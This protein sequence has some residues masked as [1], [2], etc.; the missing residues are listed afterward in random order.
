M[1]FIADLLLVCGTPTVALATSRSC[2]IDA[3]EMSDCAVEGSTA[4]W[5]TGT[6][7]YQDRT[8]E[9]GTRA[10]GTLRLTLGHFL[11]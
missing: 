5:A 2:C 9:H 6:V 8:A 1:V 3:V 11:S 7:N 10:V 4:S